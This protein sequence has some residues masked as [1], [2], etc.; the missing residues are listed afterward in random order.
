MDF[1]HLESFAAVAKARSF[2]KAAEMLFLTQPTISNHISHLEGEMNALLI[3]RSNK[4]ITLTPAG[5]LL[6]RHVLVI[7][8]E[9]DQAL[10]DLEQYK[11]RS[12]A[13]WTSPPAPPRSATC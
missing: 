13:P 2:S 11:G 9:R 12:P 4:R 3:N 5:E 1:R 8:N 7:L 6:L 10:F